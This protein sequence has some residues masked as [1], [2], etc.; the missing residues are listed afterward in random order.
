MNGKVGPVSALCLMVKGLKF[1][2]LRWRFE[3]FRAFNK[4]KEIMTISVL[5][6]INGI[7]LTAERSA[8]AGAVTVQF[9][10]SI[11]YREVHVT[12]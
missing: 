5:K 12:G 11:R 6:L 4:N 8:V 3:S 7:S 1:R 2:L 10:D 9:R